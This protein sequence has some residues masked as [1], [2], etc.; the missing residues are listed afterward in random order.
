[1][2]GA[3]QVQEQ[4]LGGVAILD[5]RGG[6]HYGQQQIHRVSSHVLH[7]AVD[8]LGAASAAVGLRH[9]VG[10]TGQLRANYRLAVLACR[11]TDQACST[12]CNWASVPS[13]RQPAKRYLNG[14][15][16]EVLSSIRSRGA[17]I[18][19]TTP[20]RHATPIWGAREPE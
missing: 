18:G 4:R 10:G 16:L 6:D 9:G 8:L 20:P 1:V 12:S 14:T 15:Y 5:G 19:Q 7:A 2:A 13:L 3:V 11:G 17:C